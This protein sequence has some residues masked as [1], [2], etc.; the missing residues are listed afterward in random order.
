[1]IFAGDATKRDPKLTP[2]AVARRIKR[3]ADAGIPWCCSWEPRFPAQ[4]RGIPASTFFD[5]GGAQLTWRAKII[6]TDHYARG[7][8]IQGWHGAYPS[9]K[10]A[11]SHEYRDKT[12][13]ELDALVQERIGE[14]RAL[15]PR[16][17]HAGQPC[18]PAISVSDAKLGSERR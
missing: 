6:C 5:P 9:A 15:A 14:H 17:I 18:S 16:W 3:L 13:A 7:E 4:E 12:I 10:A 11:G 1:M 2:V 8:T